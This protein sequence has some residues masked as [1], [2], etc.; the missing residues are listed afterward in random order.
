MIILVRKIQLIALLCL[1]ALK[2]LLF[3]V[4][5]ETACLSELIAKDLNNVLLTNQLDALT[6]NAMLLIPSVLKLKDV[7]LE[8]NYATT[9]HVPLT[10]NYVHLFN[11]LNTYPSN[12][13]MDSV[14][15]IKNS[16]T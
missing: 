4:L 12:V 7:H 2:L 15:T 14:L 10:L 1:N 6:C 9:V 3:C 16:V 8:D 5:M 13:L 11:V